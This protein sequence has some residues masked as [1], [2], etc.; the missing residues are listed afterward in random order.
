MLLDL[1]YSEVEFENGFFKQGY[2]I[3][4]LYIQNAI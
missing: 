3:Q 1:S 4:Y 2:K